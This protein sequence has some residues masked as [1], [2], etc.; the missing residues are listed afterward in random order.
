VLDKVRKSLTGDEVFGVDI[1][2]EALSVPLR[3]IADNAG[4]K[5]TVVVA[6]VAEMT[7]SKGFNALTLEY[8]DLMKDGVITPAKVDRTALQNAASVAGLLLIAD[9]IVTEAPKPK[10]DALHRVHDHDHGGGMG[11]MGGMGG[12]MGGMDF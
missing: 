11:G 5:G 4:E 12:G 8:T 9:C 6:K 10:D 1:V 2:R 7:G 3:T